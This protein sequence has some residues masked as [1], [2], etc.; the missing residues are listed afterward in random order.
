MS[1]DSHYDIGVAKEKSRSRGKIEQPWLA[2]APAQHRL[3]QGYALG[4]G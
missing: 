4:I 2:L 1:F 3:A